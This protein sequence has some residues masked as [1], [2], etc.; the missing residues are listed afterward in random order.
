[1]TEMI[2]RR[3]NFKKILLVAIAILLALIVI[4]F[5][6]VYST[7]RASL[8]QTDGT[9]EV[10]G[11]EDPITIYRDELGRPHIYALNMSDLFFGQ[12][13]AHAQD[14]L[15]QMELHR[16]A[17]EGRISEIIGRSE[18]D[19]DILLR[20]AGLPRVG[21]LL[22]NNSTP[23]TVSILGS[24]AEGVNAYLDSMNRVPPEFIL[25]GFEPEPWT[26]DQVFGVAALMAFDSASN[27]QNELF[28][29]SLQEE[30]PQL[31]YEELIPPAYPDNDVP[32][33]WTE[34]KMA[35]NIDGKELLG[36]YS[37]LDLT[38]SNYYPSLGLGSSGW[39]V[40][41]G[42]SES[43]NALFAFD[44]HDSLSMPSL[45][46]ENRLVIEGELDLYGWSV[47]GM[48]AMIDGFNRY[49]AW[50]LT[51]TGDTQ[52]LYIEERHPEDPHMFLYDD[53]WYEAEVIIDSINVSGQ[54]EPEEIEII[55]TRNGPLISEEPAISLAWTALHS[56]EGFDALLEI[57]LAENWDEF[58]DAV[59][60]FTMPSTN[61]TYADVD[62][63]IASRTA[64]L[65]PIR[66][67]GI[68]VVSMPG[69]D[70][71]YAWEGFI[72]MDEMPEV[73]N[74]GDEYV[75]AANALIARE[76]YPY[77]ISVDNA[78][79][80]R[81][82]RI[83]QYL[84]NNNLHTL[85][86]MKELQTDWYNAHAEK[87][88]PSLLSILEANQE[89]FN[90]QET[91]GMEILIEWVDKPINAMDEAGPAIFESFYLHLVRNVF[92]EEM[93]DELFEN[94][95][96]RNYVVYEV[97]ERLWDQGEGEWFKGNSLENLILASYSE[98]I[99]EL[100]SKLGDDP[101]NWR[102]D[103][104]QTIHFRHD[105]GSELGPLSG[106]YNRGPFPMGGGHTTVGRAGHRLQNPFDVS[107]VATIRVVAEMGNPIE[108]YGVIPIGQS[109]HPL[110]KH[111]DD[112]IEAWMEK[113]YYP[114]Y[115]QEVPPQADTLVLNPK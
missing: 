45:Y 9:M 54:D 13:F 96:R 1:M 11:I 65:L 61:F 102:W 6:F 101:H 31:L 104:L 42:R 106:I 112:Q 57:N 86:D 22:M 23:A 40:A 55:T 18:L 98:T 26:V 35:I 44:S 76:D 111:Y 68:G 94:F 25:L 8:P 5:V 92:G 37:R 97:V 66:S 72:P 59:K 39:C 34:E 52:D 114:V 29:L 70:S 67:Q 21:Q 91:A 110:S 36:M 85:E 14:R 49:I 105:V 4:G 62:G 50:G 81:I 108:A 100:V 88:L 15:W 90:E 95:L 83:V 93:G 60:K 12:G 43:G 7:L 20:T 71:A 109:G 33:V 16:R 27:Y 24:Y 56:D 46:Y 78:P 64:G 51:N 58:R 113:E 77:I 10:E 80:Y 28:R 107:H 69:W 75:A 74:P 115:H 53:E 41:P 3:L 103:Q 48:A 17:G 38:S 32:A 79:G 89:L 84:D 30:L 2:G 19:T 99:S 87:R 73:F 82:K 47:P 63:N